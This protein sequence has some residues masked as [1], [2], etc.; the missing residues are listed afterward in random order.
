MRPA[1]TEEPGP[2]VSWNDTPG[3]CRWRAPAPGRVCEVTSGCFVEAKQEK[4]WPAVRPLWN[5][6]AD[7]YGSYPDVRSSRS[8]GR[9]ATW[10][11]RSTGSV[12]QFLSRR[13]LR[14]PPPQRAIVV[15]DLGRN[16][17]RDRIGDGAGLNRN[18]WRFWSRIC[19][20]SGR[21]GTAPCIPRSGNC[22]RSRPGVDGLPRL[23]SR[24]GR[25]FHTD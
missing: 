24:M 25:A 12:L 21:Q 11:C 4:R 13:C 19:S 10:S 6:L 8:N 14:P 3:S 20:G 15:A 16:L 23:E 1:R 7:R 2:R 17:R 18:R 22:F 9:F 5:E